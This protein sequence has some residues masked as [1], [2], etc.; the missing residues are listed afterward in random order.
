MTDLVPILY[1]SFCFSHPP[2]S[3][4]FR[5]MATLGY[6]TDTFVNSSLPRSPKPP[7]SKISMTSATAIN[8]TTIMHNPPPSVDSQ[9]RGNDDT[10]TLRALTT[11]VRR[12]LKQPRTF[13][14]LQ[15]G[16]AVREMEIWNNDFMQAATG[17]PTLTSPEH[18]PPNPHML[19]IGC[20]YGHWCITAAR[21]FKICRV[22]GLDLADIQPNLKRLGHHDIADKISWVHSDIREDLPFPDNCFDLVRTHHLE[23]CLPENKWGRLFEEIARVL[24]PAG[25]FE[26]AH[27]SLVFPCPR[28][29]PQPASTRNIAVDG[30]E[31]D[32]R[33]VGISSQLQDTDP[34]DHSRLKA[35]F[36]AMVEVRF[37][38][39]QVISTI[40]F[41]MDLHFDNVLMTPIIHTMLP[42][43]SFVRDREDSLSGAG[44]EDTLS[45][46]SAEPSALMEQHID[47]KDMLRMAPHAA[48]LEVTFDHG[49]QMHLQMTMDMVLA[50]KE[51]MWEQ[52]ECLNPLLTRVDFDYL[53]QNWELDMRDRIDMRGVM[54]KGLK[55]DVP[56]DN[57][58]PDQRFWRHQTLKFHEQDG[59]WD[60]QH[61]P[62]PCRSFRA[63]R[64]VKHR[65]QH[66]PP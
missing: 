37:L 4:R 35:A 65:P 27:G 6:S 16:R 52:F 64:G 53:M 11:Q 3:P 47:V 57:G 34:R 42:P 25:I 49:G 22:V 17:Y 13:Y 23:F 44:M 31:R 14:P 12:Y 5:S 30:G 21:F 55:W 48:N 41:Y 1:V 43:S 46:S 54:K 58:D 15:Y 63:F 33:R 7:L 39:P 18:I 8:S 45:G 32:G 36:D 51:A 38:N 28:F 10:G 56:L 66:R 62:E 26:T 50:C 59:L 19:D 60:A 20:G 2:P 24:K 40:P 29:P 9:H 61:L